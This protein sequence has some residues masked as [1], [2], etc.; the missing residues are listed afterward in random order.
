M[1]LTFEG[2]GVYYAPPVSSVHLWS[3]IRFLE[4]V[5]SQEDLR[6]ARVCFHRDHTSSLMS[7]LVFNA[8]HFSYPIHRHQNKYESYTIVEGRCVFETFDASGR[9]LESVAMSE[10]DFLL[11]ESHDFHLIRP[12]TPNLG[13]L[14]HT[15]GPFDG[16]C[17]EYL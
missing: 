9:P 10:G 2:P 14:E 12:L 15:I 4:H 13:F 5:C 17:N 16:N 7:M 8:N 3:Y 6:T 1:N 11:N